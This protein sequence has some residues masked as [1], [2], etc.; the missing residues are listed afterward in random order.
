MSRNHRVFRKAFST[1]FYTV[2]IITHQ[3]LENIVKPFPVAVKGFVS[4]DWK[5]SIRDKENSEKSTLNTIEYLDIFDEHERLSIEK[6]A[7]EDEYESEIKRI[8]E[9]YVKKL[10]ES[11]SLDLSGDIN[12]SEEN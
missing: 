11:F 7:L 9:D 6:L 10:R 2:K 1:K 5:I 4:P 12:N 8:E 3:Y